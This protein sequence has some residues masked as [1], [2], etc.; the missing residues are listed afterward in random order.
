M[1]I[2]QVLVDFSFDRGKLGQAYRESARLTVLF[3]F[4]E[5]NPEDDS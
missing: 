1:H 4:P 3:V 5:R 2:L